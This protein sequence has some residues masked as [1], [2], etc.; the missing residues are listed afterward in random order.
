MKEQGTME[1][2]EALPRWSIHSTNHEEERR[3]KIGEAQKTGSASF[4][5][6]LE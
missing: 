1:D 2:I 5:A 6:H 4:K 3:S